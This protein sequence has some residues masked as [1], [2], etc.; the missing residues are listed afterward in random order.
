MRRRRKFRRIIKYSG[1]RNP[2][3]LIKQ[4]IM[5]L[6]TINK[7]IAFASVTFLTLTSCKKDDGAIPNNIEIEKIPA[8]SMNTATGGVTASISLATAGAFTGNF[9]ASLYFAGAEPPT[10]ID[11]AVRKN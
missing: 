1:N 7:I 2:S 5:K 4:Q 6:R 9:K 8:V 10:K 11:V 3:S